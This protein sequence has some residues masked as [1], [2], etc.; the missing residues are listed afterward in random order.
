MKTDDIP[1]KKDYFIC[2][3]ITEEATASE[4]SMRKWAKMFKPLF[5]D[6]Y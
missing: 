1:K 5:K 2:N 6:V 3:V 4:K